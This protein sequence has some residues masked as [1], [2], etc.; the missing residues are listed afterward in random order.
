MRRVCQRFKKKVKLIAGINYYLFLMLLSITWINPSLAAN[1]RSFA[2]GFTPWPWD[3]SSDAL[4]ATYEFINANSDIISH[5][6]EEGVPWTEALADT[7]FH[8]KMMD[9]WELRLQKTAP[10]LE[11]FLSISPINQLRNGMAD[12]RGSD[13]HMPIPSH[14]NGKRFNDPDVKKAYLNYAKRAVELFKPDF[15]AIAIEVNELL[16]NKP[17]DWVDFTELYIHTYLNLKHEYPNLP[18]FFTISIHNIKHD[19]PSKL[20]EMWLKMKVLWTYS[21]LAALSFYPFLQ[22]PF[23]L[24]DPISVLDE[25]KKYTD[26][27]IAISETGYPAKSVAVEALKELP[28]TP[29]IQKNVY[30]A[31]LNKA[32]ENNYHFFILWAYRD[33]DILWENMKDTLPEWGAL[34]RDVGLQDGI[35]KDRPSK[36]IW[37]L[38]KEM[39][40]R[41]TIPINFQ[42]IDE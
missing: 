17:D 41:T 35:G 18:V 7:P 40:K 3:L 25:V 14:F 29:E 31:L 37:N 8:S 23:N 12:Y 28:A 2:M 24:S 20:E 21:D 9:S 27:P 16:E 26:K 11:V 13:Y 36:G 1:T 39:P 15:L 33:Y 42:P 34:W 22:Q 38:F 32:N 4:D 6:L 19:S 30:Y 10:A 5:H